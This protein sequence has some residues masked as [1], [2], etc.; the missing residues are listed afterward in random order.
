M[1]SAC[2]VV[3]LLLC[4]E[5]SWRVQL[6]DLSPRSCAMEKKKSH[7]SSEPQFPY[8]WNWGDEPCV[9]NSLYQVLSLSLFSPWLGTEP[10]A[11]HMLCTCSTTNPHPTPPLEILILRFCFTEKPQI[12][13]LGRV[14]YPTSS[15][16]PSVMPEIFITTGF[17]PCP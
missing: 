10:R 3:E 13:G 2:C 17:H 5:D 9:R 1:P 11:A 6:M 4:P 8:M 15:R 14:I 12:G 7:C 16:T